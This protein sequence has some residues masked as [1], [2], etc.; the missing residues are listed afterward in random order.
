MKTLLASIILLLPLLFFSA[1]PTQASTKIPVLMYHYIRN[2]TYP[3]DPEGHVL[4]VSLANFNEQMDYLKTNGFTPIS[5]DTAANILQGTASVPK[6]VV[7]TFDDGTIDFYANAYPILQKYHFPATSFVITGFV[8][9][10]AYLSWNNI[11]KMQSSGLISFEDHTINHH[12]LTSLANVQILN[13]V[14]VSKAQLQQQTGQP[15]DFIAY[16]YGS[17]NS[18]VWKIIK[19][20]GYL[21]GFGTWSGQASQLSMN[22]PRVRV[23]GG[24][25]LAT[26]AKSL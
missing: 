12:S 14:S 3:G 7:L 25:S 15:V 24:E 11:Y 9:G 19:Q 21:G 26:F 2:F 6:P 22:M 10:P 13:E 16:P 4:S 20:T 18:R 17:S 23:S 1:T 5:L 8:G